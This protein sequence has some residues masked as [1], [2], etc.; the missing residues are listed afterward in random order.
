MGAEPAI[1]GL[2]VD[3]GGVLTTD[4]FSSFEAF[5][6]REGLDPMLVRDMFRGDPEA[7]HTLFS[8]ETGDL[9]EPEFEL[10]FARILGLREDRASG[11]IDRLFSGMKEDIV[12][13]T[14]VRSARAQ[15]VTT[16]LLSNSW[17]V[18]RYDRSHFPQL[19]D[20]VVIS[21]EEGVRKPD[22]AIY[23]TALARMSMPAAEV[24][25]VDD[26]PGNLK[27]ARDLGMAT[28]LHTS[29]GETVTQLEKLL[30]LRL[31]DV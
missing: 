29:G 2:L 25:F 8:L 4:V 20:A 28:V 26:L 10:K 16:G 7:R 12:M 31:R 23:E 27:P 14:A 21:G 22:R 9:T 19:F 15:G 13:F 3:W 17:G 24:V 1:R 5:C 30:G 18:D 6:R 11:L